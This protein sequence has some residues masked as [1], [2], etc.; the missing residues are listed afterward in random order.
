MRPHSGLLLPHL[1]RLRQWGHSQGIL[2]GLRQRTPATWT[3]WTT[4]SLRSIDVVSGPAGQ[5]NWDRFRA[6]FVPDG[7]IV[8]IVPESAATKDAPARKGDAVFLTPDMFAQQNDSY[9]KTHSA[10]IDLRLDVCDAR[11]SYLAVSALARRVMAA[12]NT[13]CSV[14]PRV[15]IFHT[16][17]SQLIRS[18]A[19]LYKARVIPNVVAHASDGNTLRLAESR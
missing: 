12:M 10:S 14:K 15:A 2:T 19:S 16:T 3:L 1:R 17:A 9:F 11:F 13:S 6:L 18:I 5:R 8:S 7:R 4:W